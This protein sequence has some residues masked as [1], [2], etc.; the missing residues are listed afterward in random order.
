VIITENK[1]DIDFGELNF[2][3]EVLTPKEFIKRF[4]S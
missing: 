2:D 4:T 1:K 3:F